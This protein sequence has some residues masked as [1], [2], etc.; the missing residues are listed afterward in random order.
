MGDAGFEG[1]LLEHRFDDQV[2]AL[3][4][5]GLVGGRDL[6]QQRSAIVQAHAAAVHT[7]LRDPGAVGFA[8]LGFFQAHVLEHGGNTTAGLRI[9]DPGTHH[10]GTHHTHFERC[11][12]W[13]TFGAGL[14]RLDRVHIEKERV[15]H[16]FR[17]RA[18]DKSGEV[19]AL[20]TQ[21]GIEINLRPFDHRCQCIFG[22]RVQSARRPLHHGW[23]HCQRTR[24][25]WVAGQATR[26]FVSLVVPGLGR[27]RVGCYPG[28]RL[29]A[30]LVCLGH[31]FV[32]Q[33]EL[34]RFAWA[35]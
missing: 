29:D 12:T 4:V 10:A 35:K 30:Q 26:H 18:C 7:R 24:N 2:A 32:H 20:N 31:K 23:G 15:D 3:Q 19:T 33:A 28:Q 11:V 22:G 25:L 9:R 8:G 1:T 13:Y 27:Y 6:R 16:V 17:H 21:R 14:S 34:E 5:C